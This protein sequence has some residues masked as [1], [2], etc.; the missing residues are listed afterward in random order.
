MDR[1]G[2]KQFVA[3]F[4][5]AFPDFSLTIDQE[6]RDGD[7]GAARWRCTGTFTGTSPLWPVAPTGKAV[8]VSGGHFVA[9]R[10]ERP[11]EVWHHGDWMGGLQQCGVLPPLG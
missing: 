5:Q 3:G 7:T 9:W 11:L 4:H 10:D 1:E 8:A 2:L 6:I